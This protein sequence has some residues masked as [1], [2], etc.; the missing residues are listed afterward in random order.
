MAMA[1]NAVNMPVDE[2]DDEARIEQL[3]SEALME[4]YVLLEK[5]CPHPK[6][7]T[8]L[9]K[10]NAT[11]TDGRAVDKVL[12]PMLVPSQS[13]EQ[14]FKPIDGVP[15][16]VSC[17]AHVV[18]QESEIKILERCDSLKSKGGILVA[19]TESVS[20]AESTVT[21]IPEP[22]IINVEPEVIDVTCVDVDNLHLF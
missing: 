5:S 14:P 4:G 15:F 10:S 11:E 21:A 13:F 20:T 8:P 6:C 3:L 17:Q 19:M 9:V 18:T 16:C 1:M 22:E 12:E 7:A 2:V